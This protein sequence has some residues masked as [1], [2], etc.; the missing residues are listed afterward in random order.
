M[1][2]HRFAPVPAMSCLHGVRSLALHVGDAKGLRGL[3]GLSEAV[4]NRAWI[5]GS[6]LRRCGAPWRLFSALVACGDGPLGPR[7]ARTELASL[8]YPR[9]S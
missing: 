3:N 6:R 1:R 9:E 5:G 2:L 8:A 7:T 4:D